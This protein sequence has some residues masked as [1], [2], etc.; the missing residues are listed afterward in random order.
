MRTSSSK[1]SARTPRRE[2]GRLRVAGLL[3]AAGAVF[4]EKGFDG[5]TMTEIAARAG[6][7]IGSLY[8]FF[9]TKELLADALMDRDTAVLIEGLAAFEAAA[10]AWSPVDLADRLAPALIEFRAE[11]PAFA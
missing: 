10:P 9:P 7:S 3:E 4:A 2:R 1:S 11:H 8:Q 5:A 6:A